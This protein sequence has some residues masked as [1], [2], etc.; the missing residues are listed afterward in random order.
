MHGT[1]TKNTCLLP[2]LSLLLLGS[3]LLPPTVCLAGTEVAGH[4][5]QTVGLAADTS[6]VAGEI[7]DPADAGEV[8]HNVLRVNSGIGDSTRD[9]LKFGGG[10]TYGPGAVH[11]NEVIVGRDAATPSGWRV[12]GYHWIGDISNMPDYALFGGMAHG[13]EAVGDVHHNRVTISG[14]Y[15]NPDTFTMNYPVFGGVSLRTGVPDCGSADVLYNEVVV[16]NVGAPVDSEYY[17]FSLGVCGGYTGGDAV[18]NRVTV[19]NSSDADYTGAQSHGGSVRDNHVVL[20]GVRLAPGQLMGFSGKAVGAAAIETTDPD[21]TVVGNTAVA[22]G[23]SEIFFLCGAVS[24]GHFKTIAENTAEI[25]PGVRVRWLAGALEDEIRGYYYRKRDDG[26]V[27]PKV[28]PNKI[29]E[30]TIAERNTVRSRGGSAENVYGGQNWAAVRNEVLLSGGVYG[31]VAGGACGVVRDTERIGYAHENTVRISDGASVWAVHGGALSIGLFEGT[32]NR[33]RVFLKDSAVEDYVVGGNGTIANENRVELIGATVGGSVDG[34]GYDDISKEGEAQRNSVVI[35]DS[36]IESRVTGGSGMIANE[37]GVELIGSVIGSTVTGGS[38]VV[39]TDNRIEI[40]GCTVDSAS[41]AYGEREAQRNRVVI[42]DSA[43]TYGVGGSL[44]GDI[45]NDNE[46]EIFGCTVGGV[47]GANGK[48]E[49]R[50]NRV[51]IKDSAVRADVFGGNGGAAEENSVELANSRVTGSVG[52]SLYAEKEANRNSVVLQMT[53]V[54]GDVIGGH[55]A[56]LSDGLTAH[57][58]TVTLFRT[59]VGGDVAGG[60]I[61]SD[62]G[63]GQAHGN[64]ITLEGAAVTGSLGGGVLRSAE[65]VR[66]DVSVERACATQRNRLNIVCD[67]EGP[68]PHSTAHNI[69]SHSVQEVNF[70][71]DGRAKDRTS[72]LLRLTDTEQDTDLRDATFAVAMRSGGDAFRVGEEISLLKTGSSLR[73][74][75]LVPRTLGT[76]EVSRRPPFML[77]VRNTASTPQDMRAPDELYARFVGPGLTDRTKSFVQMSAGA[78]DFVRRSAELPLRGI[79]SAA[80]PDAQ[81]RGYHLWTVTDRGRLVSGSADA[82]IRTD[83]WNIAGGWSRTDT[84]NGTQR[85]LSPYVVYGKGT[86]DAYLGDGTSGQGG[87]SSLG[88]GVFGRI[89]RPTGAWMEAALHGGTVRSDYSGSIAPDSDSRVVLS[90]PYYG[91]YLGAG[92]RVHAGA[93]STV[94]ASVR[95]FGTYQPSADTEIRSTVKLPCGETETLVERYTFDAVSSH[96]LRLGVLYAYRMGAAHE[97]SAGL[98]YEY[99]LAGRA[100]A[101][102]DGLSAPAVS[103]QGGSLLLRL[104]YR[105]APPNGRFSCEVRLSEWQGVRRG[106]IGDVHLQWKV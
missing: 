70:F 84:K 73:T 7:T 16:R 96:R 8:H 44:G 35:K 75:S 92:K 105:F 48:G 47:G 17:A 56:V 51:V 24:S 28:Y 85:V 106:L 98:A 95:Y 38:G 69:V 58:N 102:F 81:K 76:I 40:A 37:N 74:G 67:T 53:T 62:D 25:G 68:Q 77:G 88:L 22:T 63:S 20:D 32:T 61:D 54:E 71:L 55:L 10:M 1:V 99:E 39:A 59:Q 18:G 94:D 29:K 87:I 101:S 52:G 31:Y 11:H 3:T 21:R 30:G 78:T 50:R 46:V 42:K 19:S 80:V 43:V 45:A 79:A 83:G 100:G 89:E 86:Y 103:L 41:G 12:G 23:D 64:T 49:V 13:T 65:G 91:I 72:P 27:T 97:V 5:R 26:V 34:G 36:K 6:L 33:N 14:D 15:A 66:G 60:R 93:H 104:G 9:D 4:E 2:S 57:G 90:R 82:E